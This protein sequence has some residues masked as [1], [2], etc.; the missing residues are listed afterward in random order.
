MENDRVTELALLACRLLVKAY[1][2][3]LYRA[4]EFAGPVM[5]ALD[6]AYVA[7]VGAIRAEAEAQRADDDNVVD[8][9]QWLKAASFHNS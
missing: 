7:A 6:A 3:G 2:G 1:C 9:A 8:L 4:G 5:G